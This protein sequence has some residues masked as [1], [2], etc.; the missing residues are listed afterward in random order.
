MIILALA[1]GL[2]IAALQYGRAALTRRAA[3][4]ALL[5][6]L[7]G[8]IVASLLLDVPVGRARQPS[9][10]VAL[11]AS[12]SW[13]RAAAGCAAWRAALDSASRLGGGHWWRFGDSL[14]VD[15]GSGPPQDRASALRVVADRAAGTGRPV[16]VITDGELDDPESVAALPRG[17]RAI[18]AP[19]APARDV[20][21]SRLD[22]PRTVLAGDSLEA[23]LTLVAGGAGSAAGR[24]EL[25]LDDAVIA[26]Q[27]VPALA[28]FAELP[29]QL[30]GVATGA[31]HAALLHAIVRAPGD[32]EP[33]N[34]TLTVTVDVSRSA[35]AVFVS[36]APDFDAR[37]AVAALRG[38]TSL[39][40]RAYYRVAPGAWR[41]DGTL[42]S[43]TES[44][45]AAALRDAPLAVI[46]GDT[47][48]FGAPRALTRGSLLL[49]AP[50]ATDEGE[51][52]ASAAPPSPLAPALASLPF[53]SLPPLNVAPT[54]PR[55]S[56][57]GL[58]VRRGGAQAT[59]T[60]LVG[61]D[62]PRRIAVLGAQGFWRWRFR[63]GV[64]AE[65]YDAFFGSLYD[66]LVEGRSDRRLAVPAMQPIRSGDAVRWRRGGADSVVQLTITRRSATG[67]VYSVLLHFA[68]TATVAESPALAP[69]LYDVRMP[70]G[71][72]LLAVNESRELVPRRATVKSGAVGGSGVAGEAP[73]ARD[74]TWLFLLAVL[75]LCAEWWLRRRAGLR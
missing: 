50:P 10:D 68:D 63:G 58:T 44:E 62:A 16:V 28:A 2:V 15:D 52:Y 49:F 24:V 48:L 71:Q 14:R 29:V 54:L 66:W 37:E 61:I 17:S 40:T 51:W 31:P 9:A 38:V 65:A 33:R 1:I 47:T 72:A 59:R 56:W 13:Q 43:V 11:D 73:S 74:L 64:R 35:A 41:T 22:A 67:R 3:P 8:F 46:H 34:D 19:C 4:L 39:P 36:T 12:M 53:D 20:A 23:R 60:A 7:A 32:A 25:R 69:G 45:V 26:A 75:L 18:V 6:A 42:A 5:R 55:G 21:V 27:D 70:G 57:Q 30:R